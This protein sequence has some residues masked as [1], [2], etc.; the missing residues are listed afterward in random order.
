M[1]DI[2]NALLSRDNKI[3]LARRSSGRPT[4]PS[5]WSF[6]G[7]HVE[8]GESLGDALKREMQEEVGLIPLAFSK[9][10]SIVEPNPQVNG[11]VVYHMYAVNAWAGGEPRILGDEHSELR[12]FS[13]DAACALEGLALTEYVPIL[14]K[15]A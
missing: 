3:L 14:R 15:L 6:P 7:G 13:I 9:I 12:W 10:G 8:T 1:R 11:N 4:Y 2:V 5:R